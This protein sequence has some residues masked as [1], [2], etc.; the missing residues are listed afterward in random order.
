M[1]YLGVKTKSKKKKKKKDL[2]ILSQDS[3]D[4]QGES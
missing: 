4:F 2:I 3:G 1:A